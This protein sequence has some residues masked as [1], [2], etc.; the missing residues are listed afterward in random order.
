MGAR[1]DVRL[2]FEWRGG[3]LWCGSDAAR[4]AFDVG[5]IEDQWPRSPGT[6][7]QLVELSAWHDGALNWDDPPAPSPWSSDERE[8]FE[9][10]AAEVL[11]AVRAEVGP[12]F[13]VVYVPL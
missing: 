6:R 2:M 9:R 5:P 11:A 1:Y 8:R 13:E 3:C 7:R 10:A 4:A 12:E